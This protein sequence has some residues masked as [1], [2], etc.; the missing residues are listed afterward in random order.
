MSRC[1]TC[2]VTIK[3]SRAKPCIVNRSWLEKDAEVTSF[4][5]QYCSICY[6]AYLIKLLTK[7]QEDYLTHGHVHSAISDLISKWNLEIAN[8]NES[9]VLIAL[10][11][12]VDKQDETGKFGFTFLKK[13][14]QKQDWKE[15]FKGNDRRIQIPP[16]ILKHIETN[17][18]TYPLGS[19]KY[20]NFDVKI[21]EDFEF[22]WPEIKTFLSAN[23]PL[24][25]IPVNFGI[26]GNSNSS[27]YRSSNS[28]NSNSSSSSSSNSNSN[29]SSVN[30]PAEPE[31]LKKIPK[32]STEETIPSKE[33]KESTSTVPVSKQQSPKRKVEL[34]GEASS[35]SNSSSANT[36][37]LGNPLTPTT[38]PNSSGKRQK[39]DQ[40]SLEATP[41]K[42][43]YTIAEL[44]K[45]ICKEFELSEDLSVE[46][47][48]NLAA[49][50]LGGITFEIGWNNKQK[51]VY[52]L[53]N[54][55]I[56]K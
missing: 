49:K 22:T 10:T 54:V 50:E 37:I 40:D 28:N 35:S 55:N 20:I 2:S 9:V 29:S 7:T 47:L 1:F 45:M 18:A 38:S 33:R 46:D 11:I 53:K 48:C 39:V 15:I 14:L 27:S 31:I 23:G 16:S 4:A 44:K 26:D 5:R 17:K 30:G 52:I 24:P 21:V 36:R 12:L 41:H 13:E 19:D 32:L 6:E 56:I 51:A 25:P 8:M 3:N 34:I 42:T 43:K